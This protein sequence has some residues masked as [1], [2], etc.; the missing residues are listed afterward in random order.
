MAKNLVTLKEAIQILNEV[1]QI[2][3]KKLGRN[4]FATQ[5]IY[6]AIAKKKLKRYGP[7][8]ILQVDVEELLRVFGP[9]KVA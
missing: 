9:K 7:Y 1:H 2:D 3:P 5:T 4:A 8:H 6:N